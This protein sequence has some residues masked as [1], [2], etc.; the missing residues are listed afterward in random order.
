MNMM[1]ND[2]PHTPPPLPPSIP[3]P[4]FINMMLNDSQHML[5]DA[6]ETLPKVGGWV[7]MVGG[8]GRGGGD[9][10]APPHRTQA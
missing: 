6:L 8:W 5:Q 1:L 7:G 4:Q 10:V 9:G 2:S 3:P